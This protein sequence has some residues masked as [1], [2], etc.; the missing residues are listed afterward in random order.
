MGFF[1]T[2]QLA[3][4]DFRSI[5][6]L[7]RLHDGLFIKEKVLLKAIF[8]VDKSFIGRRAYNVAECDGTGFAYERFEI[9]HATDCRVRAV[10]GRSNKRCGT[11]RDGRDKTAGGR[12][13][14]V[15]GGG[16]RTVPYMTDFLSLMD[17]RAFARK[18]FF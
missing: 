4:L 10:T 6:R 5:P 2:E 17:S 15:S 18:T 3:T 7:V 9:H 14:G 11:R 13:I 8:K 16:T 1:E 12:I